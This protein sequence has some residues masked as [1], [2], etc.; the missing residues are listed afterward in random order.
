VARWGNL[1][2]ATCCTTRN[3]GRHIL[4]H[5]HLS[6]SHDRTEGTSIPL[7][8]NGAVHP[9]QYLS[10]EFVFDSEGH[11]KTFNVAKEKQPDGVWDSWEKLRLNPDMSDAELKAAYKAS[12]AKYSLGDR[13]TFKRELPVPS[14]PGNA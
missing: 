10:T 4:H 5:L 7:D 8:S 13:E 14:V 11:L 2:E 12:G 6:Q 1:L 3:W 9:T